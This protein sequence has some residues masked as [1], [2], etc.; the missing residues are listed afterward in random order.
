MQYKF[1]DAAEEILR[2]AGKPLH[3][4]EITNI[5]LKKGML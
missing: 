2:Q 3:N 4:N 1:K 5:A